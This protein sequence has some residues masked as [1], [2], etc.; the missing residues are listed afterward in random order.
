VP[1]TLQYKISRDNEDPNTFHIFEEYTYRAE[2]VRQTY[3]IKGISG[4]RCEWSVDGAVAAEDFE[5]AAAAVVRERSGIE[6]NNRIDFHA[7][8]LF[9]LPI[10]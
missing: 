2:C 4:I 10:E 8:E 5:A 7:I 1:G 6:E 9:R 3:T